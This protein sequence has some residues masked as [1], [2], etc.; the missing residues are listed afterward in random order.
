MLKSL[1]IPASVEKYPLTAILH[2]R[3]ESP[4]FGHSRR[5]PKCVIENRDAIGGFCCTKGWKQKNRQHEITKMSKSHN[6]LLQKARL[7]KAN[8]VADYSSLECVL[9]RPCQGA[10][11][12][13]L[14]L[15]IVSDV[16]ECPRFRRTI[17]HGPMKQ[18]T[19]ANLLRAS[20]GHRFV[21]RIG[22]ASTL[23]FAD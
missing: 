20:E 1:G 6:E 2:Q 10:W 22:T 17:N 13:A 3:G 7:E 15:V 21:A 9:P 14:C 19:Y 4:G 11:S 16:C 8:I 12:V 23:L 5:L 18:S